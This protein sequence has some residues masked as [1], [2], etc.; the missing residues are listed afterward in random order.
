M[1]IFSNIEAELS[2]S[3]S[4]PNVAGAVNI[5]LAHEKIRFLQGDTA[6]LTGSLSIPFFSNPLC[7][8]DPH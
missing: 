8:H 2:N 7:G 3:K 1:D 5:Q 4:S 6:L